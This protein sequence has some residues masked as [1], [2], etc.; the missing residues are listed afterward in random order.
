MD[1]TLCNLPPRRHPV[2]THLIP[3]SHA[4]AVGRRSCRLAGHGSSI[5]A[6][7]QIA[8]RLP[9]CSRTIAAAATGPID[10]AANC[11]ART[12]SGVMLSSLRCSASPNARR[13]R[14]HRRHHERSHR[15]ACEHS[16]ARSLSI[17]A[18]IPSSVRSL[19]ATQD[20]GMPPPRRRS[21][22]CGSS[23]QRLGGSRDPLRSGDSHDRRRYSPSR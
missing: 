19:P 6:R 13:R 4:S 14:P 10:P 5:S 7:E 12:C 16:L 11:C 9:W 3:Y 15:S 18:S 1:E 22:L 20:V 2:V 17:T 8:A 23:S 21:Q